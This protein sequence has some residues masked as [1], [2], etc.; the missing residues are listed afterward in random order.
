MP[1]TSPKSP[2]PILGFLKMAGKPRHGHCTPKPSPTYRSWVSMRSRC[3]NPKDSKYVVYGGSGITVCERWHSF[4]NFLEDMGPRP[5]GTT[6]DR[7]P[8]RAGNYELGNC[9]WATYS[10]QNFNRRK[11]KRKPVTLCRRG[12]LFVQGPLQKECRICH[13]ETVKR[14]R[15]RKAALGL[16]PSENLRDYVEVKGEDM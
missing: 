10:E 5:K 16:K 1:T 4:E 14:F 3:Y 11:Y 9:R 15:A 6:I 12:H 8:N 2:I 7:Y 13:N